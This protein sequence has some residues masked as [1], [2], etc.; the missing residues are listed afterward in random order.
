[1]GYL[2]GLFIY[3]EYFATDM[4]LLTVDTE[5]QLA[6][7][8][9]YEQYWKNISPSTETAILPSVEDTARWLS[10]SMERSGLHLQ[11]LVCGSVSLVGVVMATLNLTADNL[12]E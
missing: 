7:Y 6:K 1:M 9:E 8:N 3:H 12:Y 5:E 10:S 4:A 2:F 11:V